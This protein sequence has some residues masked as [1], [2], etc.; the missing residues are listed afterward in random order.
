MTLKALDTLVIVKD[1]YSQL[2]YP[3]ILNNLSVKI[4]TQLVIEVATEKHTCCTKLCAF[5]CLIKG[6]G[7]E[8]F[9]CL[10]EKLPLSQK[11]CYFRGSHFFTMFYT[12]L[13]VTK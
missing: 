13:L 10:S 6:F 8:V 11:Q 1:H 9:C 7:P 3:Y 4:L 2:V 12:P 5:R